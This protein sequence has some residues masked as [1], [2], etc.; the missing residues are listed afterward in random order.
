MSA[1][2]LL[3]LKTPAMSRSG[4]NGN[5]GSSSPW[6]INTCPC[7]PYFVVLCKQTFLV[8]SRFQDEELPPSSEENKAVT[9]TF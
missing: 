9:A 1:R 3:R 6:G 8:I 4:N 2:V 5:T 7:F